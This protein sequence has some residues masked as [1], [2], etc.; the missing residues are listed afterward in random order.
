MVPLTPQ[1]LMASWRVGVEEGS[2]FFWLVV[3]MGVEWIDSLAGMVVIVVRCS[4]GLSG[5]CGLDLERF[6]SV[7][8][9]EDGVVVGGGQQVIYLVF[10]LLS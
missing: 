1:M 4:C 9:E 3:L 10:L 6:E 8:G 5:D 7:L 2:F